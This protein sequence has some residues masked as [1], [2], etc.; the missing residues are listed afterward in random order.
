M[1]YNKNSKE[2]EFIIY[3]EEEYINFKKNNYFQNKS[4]EKDNLIK[5]EEYNSFK[6]GIKPTYKINFNLKNEISYRGL[7]NVG[8]TCYMNATLQCLANKK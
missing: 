8:A 2:V 7:E 4:N 5:S 6:D 1:Q 3:N